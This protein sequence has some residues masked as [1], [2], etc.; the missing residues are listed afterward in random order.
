VIVPVPSGFTSPLSV[1]VSLAEPP[2]LIELDESC[3]ATVGVVALTTDVSPVAPHV[4]VAALL[5]ASPPKLATHVY[6]PGAVG[7]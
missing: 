1:A 2:A 7:G 3:V 4:L 6:V 5:L